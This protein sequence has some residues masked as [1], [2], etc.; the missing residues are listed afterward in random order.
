MSS[1]TTVTKHTWS[2][3][4]TTLVTRAFL[5]G[6]SIKEAHNLVPNIKLISVKQKYTTC[7]SLD[8]KK[9][10][11][12]TKMHLDVWEE[13]KAALTVPDVEAASTVEEEGSSGYWSDDHEEDGET[14]NLCA[15]TCNRVCHYEE[16]DGDGMC[17]KCQFFHL[18]KGGAKPKRK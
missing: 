11:G 10:S 1:T 8:K 7:A 15:G 6:K 9:E 12:V 16:T 18:S 4:E 2:R 13:L 3:E 14:Y 17:G 5:E